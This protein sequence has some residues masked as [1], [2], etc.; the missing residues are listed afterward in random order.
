[1]NIT[2]PAGNRL[3]IEYR[4]ELALDLDEQKMAQDNGLTLAWQFSFWL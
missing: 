4:K 1:M 2:L 3:A